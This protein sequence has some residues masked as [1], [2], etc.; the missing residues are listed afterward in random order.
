MEGMK[1]WIE[2]EGNGHYFFYAFPF[3]VILLLFLLR[4]RRVKFV[5]PA[6]LI[7]LIIVNP[8]FYEKWTEL[9][10][11]AY[12]RILWIIPVIPCLASLVPSITEKIKNKG[13][14]RWVYNAG[15][16][17]IVALGSVGI[18]LGGTFLYNGAG[19]SFVEAASA[20][21][22]PEATVT[23]ANR[24]LELKERPRIIADPSISVYI[25]QYTGK[26]QSLFGRDVYGYMGWP[27]DDAWSAYHEI[28]NPESDLSTVNRI[29][30]EEGYDYLVIKD[31]GSIDKFDRVDLIG[32]YAV[33]TAVGIP[34]VKKERNELGQII[35][36]TT[37]GDNGKPVNNATGYATT[38]YDYD[39]RNNIIYE[40][41]INTEGIG[42]QDGNGKV[43]YRRTFDSKDRIIDQKT[44]GPDGKSIITS[45]GYAEYRREYKGNNLISESFY[46]ENG[47]LV[48]S[49]NGYAREEREYDN[50]SNMIVQRFLDQNGS[51]V[52]TAS[53]FAEKKCEYDNG[54]LIKETYFD[55]DRKPMIQAAGHFAIE[56]TWDGEELLSRTYLDAD[57]LPVNRIDGYS[58]VVWTKNKDGVTNVSFYDVNGSEVNQQGLNLVKDVKYGPDGWSEWMVP[59]TNVDNYGFG[60]GVAQLGEKTEGDVI[61]CQI[62]IEFSNVTA[63]EGQAFRLIAQGPTDGDWGKENV[64]D[65]RLVGI[66]ECPENGI[67]HF[68]CVRQITSDMATID[69]F[70]LGF[71]C[72]QWNGG[73]FRIRDVKVEKCE[74]ESAW[75]PGL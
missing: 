37:L 38:Y 51:L 68:L 34:T 44:L 30:L 74:E 62:D 57:G 1:Y 40:F 12:W 18:L 41:H 55:S 28:N 2:S 4:K 5:I 48:N 15:I 45:I 24:L 73:K 13:N 21:K 59:E 31:R 11:Y 49:I 63:D 47:K 25:R 61:T 9:G 46:N 71:R 54:K 32:D 53:G 29:M 22:L 14:K 3:V 6:I 35:S 72:D 64:W 65:W 58:K 43:G 39:E 8:W 33:Y 36:I 17:A 52:I 26:I 27:S 69:S 66:G 67:Y 70:Y 75:T 56:Q 20:A 42:V 16:I 7:T 50:A 10:L 23:V 19:G 60:V